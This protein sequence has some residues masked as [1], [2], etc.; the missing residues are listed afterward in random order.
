M[1]GKILIAYFSHE[2]ETHVGGGKIEKL[3]IGNTKRVVNMIVSLTGAD[4]FRIETTIPYPEDYME[5]IE[6]ANA[7]QHTDARPELKED[8]ENL[9]E[10]DTV[11]LGYP[12]WWGAMPMAVFHFLENHVWTGKTILP[13]CTHQ[14]SGLSNSEA[15]IKRICTGAKVKKGLAIMGG[16]IDEA[17]AQI[18]EWLRSNGLL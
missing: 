13:F 16:Q 14:G 5:T 10:Y 1:E 18:E 9:E 11:I 17:Q 15:D 4:T 12:N 8:I 2:G 7:E 6:I 3:V